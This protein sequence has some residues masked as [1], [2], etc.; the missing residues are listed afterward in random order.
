MAPDEEFEVWVHAT[1]DAAYDDPA[2][3][4]V[5]GQIVAR[6]ERAGP[7][8]LRCEA[9]R[10]HDAGGAD[11]PGTESATSPGRPRQPA[12]GRLRE[13]RLGP[14]TKARSRSSSD[15]GGAHPRRDRPEP[16]TT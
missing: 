12:T 4:A 10:D 15:G 9:A 2:V 3:T 13:A 8:Q 16:F 7:Q 14:C 1:L 6:I 11:V 5:V